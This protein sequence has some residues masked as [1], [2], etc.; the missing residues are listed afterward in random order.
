MKR[1]LSITALSMM[2][3]VVFPATRYVDTTPPTNSLVAPSDTRFTLV[4]VNFE[5]QSY[6]LSTILRFDTQTGNAWYFAVASD[7]NPTW[8]W[9]LITGAP[10]TS[11]AKL[12]PVSFEY[13]SQKLSTVIRMDTQTGNAWYFG[14]VPGQKPDQ[15]P[16]WNWV[17]IK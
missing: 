11:F 5:Y 3:I 12:V 9:I 16:T 8:S 17:S 10:A 1:F 2:A 15:G 14:V 4:P 6:K 7:Q 13:K